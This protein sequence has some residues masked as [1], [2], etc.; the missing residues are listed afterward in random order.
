M[1]FLVK[2]DALMTQARQAGDMSERWANAHLDKLLTNLWKRKHRP[3]A[4]VDLAVVRDITNIEFALWALPVSE[5]TTSNDNVDRA[6]RLVACV[7]ARWVVDKWLPEAATLTG[8]LVAAGT[9]DD[10]FTDLSEGRRPLGDWHDWLCTVKAALDS[11]EGE[12]YEAA[13]RMAALSCAMNM[14]AP[15]DMDR[16]P[17]KKKLDPLGRHCAFSAYFDACWAWVTANE[18]YRAA[19]RLAAIARRYADWQDFQEIDSTLSEVQTSLLTGAD[20]HVAPLADA[21]FERF[22]VRGW[23]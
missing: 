3:G 16:L 17:A 1:S 21:A 7:M 15:S 19:Y 11:M 23:A 18:G 22:V 14:V 20:P 8:G 13:V 12:G 5:P 4:P 9:F 2:I 6:G 10:L